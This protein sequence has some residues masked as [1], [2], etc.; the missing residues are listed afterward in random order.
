VRSYC[1][2]V[3]A[4]AVPHSTRVSLF[5]RLHVEEMVSLRSF[6]DPPVAKG[7]TLKGSGQV[8]YRLHSRNHT[9]AVILEGTQLQ[10]QVQK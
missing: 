5:E 6:L 4:R 9:S 1:R 8:A 3:V 10:Q 2:G 7:T